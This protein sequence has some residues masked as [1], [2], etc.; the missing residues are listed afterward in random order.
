MGAIVYVRVKVPGLHRWPGAPE[1]AGFLKEEHRHLFHIEVGFKVEGLDREL[2]FFDLQEEVLEAV[3]SI[4]YTHWSGHKFGERS[5]EMI[6]A[7]LLDRL[8]GAVYADVSEDGENGAR[9]ERR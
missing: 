1:R 3:K 8:N 6:A 5:C 4:G 7:E 9:V 2:E